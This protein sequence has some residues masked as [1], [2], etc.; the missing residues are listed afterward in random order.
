MFL[1]E[2]WDSWQR[3]RLERERER[4]RE[5]DERVSTA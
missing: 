4:E 3:L 5:R 1:L 2:E